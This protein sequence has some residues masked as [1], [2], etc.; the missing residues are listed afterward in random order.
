MVPLFALELD[1]INDV[2]FFLIIF[3]VL[4]NVINVVSSVVL[5][6]SNCSNFMFVRSFKQI[7]YFTCCALTGVLDLIYNVAAPK[8]VEGN[9]LRACSTILFQRYLSLWGV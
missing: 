8:L 2:P 9:F 3:P 5:I 4:F 1:Q 6:D 7:E